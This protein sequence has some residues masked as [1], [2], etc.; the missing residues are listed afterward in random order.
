MNKFQGACA[1]EALGDG[2][3]DAVSPANFNLVGVRYFDETL[4]KSL[5][6]DLTQDEVAQHFLRFEPLPNSLKSPLA[7]RYHGHQFRHYN[8]DIGDGRGF[9][10]AQCVSDGKLLDFGT[11]GSGQT[12]FSRS[13]DGRRRGLGRGP[14]RAAR[15]PPDPCDRRRGRRPWG[16]RRDD[17]RQPQPVRG[18]RHQGLR[19]RRPQVDRR[20][21]VRDRSDARRRCATVTA[22][23]RVKPHFNGNFFGATSGIVSG[24]NTST[25]R[26]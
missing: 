4:S 13:G 10:F 15:R 9:L 24:R 22:I 20:T 16:G 21:A 1:I 19:S 18:Q 5:G 25:S 26:Q 12:P 23:G 6:L 3:Y 17:L 14:G 7:L 2:F 8:P 11:K